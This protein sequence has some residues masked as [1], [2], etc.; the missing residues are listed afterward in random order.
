MVFIFTETTGFVDNLFAC[1]TTKNYLGNPPAKED[2]KTPVQ[3][4][5]EKEEVKKIF[6]YIS[7]KNNIGRKSENRTVTLLLATQNV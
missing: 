4:V 1:L 7:F 3:K 2:I 6:N 5:E